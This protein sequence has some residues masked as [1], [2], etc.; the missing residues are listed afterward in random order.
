LLHFTT[1]DIDEGGREGFYLMPSEHRGGEG[2]GEGANKSERLF[3]EISAR[4]IYKTWDRVVKGRISA[5]AQE[6]PA[7]EAH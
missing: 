4:R 6:L 5:G 1:T 2:W 3:D 7:M